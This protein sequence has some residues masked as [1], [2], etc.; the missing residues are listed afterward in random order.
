MAQVA[1]ELG[2]LLQMG[3]VKMTVCYL[4]KLLVTSAERVE[5]SNKGFLTTGIAIVKVSLHIALEMES[6]LMKLM[7]HLHSLL[8]W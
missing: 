3:L 6:C 4:L 5:L 2:C 1:Y 8:Q 7:F